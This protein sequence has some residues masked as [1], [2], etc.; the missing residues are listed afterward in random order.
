[1]K[2]VHLVGVGGSGMSS[3]AVVLAGRGYAVS[4]SDRDHDRGRNAEL[5]RCLE[6]TGITLVP[7]DGGAVRAGDVDAV[8]VSGAVESQVP[9]VAVAREMGVAVHRRAEV[10]V[11]LLKTGRNVAVAGTSGKSTVTAMAAWILRRAGQSPSFLGGAPLAA[12]ASPH[13]EP[14]R[15]PGPGA[16]MGTSDL[17]VAEA[18]ESDGTL[19][20]YTPDVGIITNVSEDHGTLEELKEQFTAFA[21]AV[22]ICLVLHADPERRAGWDPPGGTRRRTFGLTGDAHTRADELKLTADGSSFRVGDA[23]VHLKVPGR[24]NVENALA[25]IAAAA[26]LGVPVPAA[27]R[28]LEGF[29]GISRRMEQVGQAAGVRV[30]DDFA[31]NPDKVASALQA[32]REGGRRL[33]VA[34]QLHGFGPARMH[35][36]GLAEAFAAGLGEGDR[37]YLL[38]IYYAGGTVQRDISSDDYVA[39]LEAMGVDVHGVEAS[40]ALAARLAG[41][42]EGGDTLVIMGA[43]NPN[44]PVLARQ[45]LA[46]LEKRGSQLSR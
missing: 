21:A 11:K 28:A 14:G 9:D 44:L 10:L 35:R 26:A 29:P 46:E 33:R 25:A 19:V 38:P 39:D 5:F 43:R 34:F 6:E 42:C 20:L 4:G 2:R 8:V 17:T 27:C 18:D 31:H 16:W 45:V 40:N 15:A 7:Q 41:D 24:F 37:L 30:V 22:K 1:M 12:Q 23:W 13:V 3:L 32:L 36:R